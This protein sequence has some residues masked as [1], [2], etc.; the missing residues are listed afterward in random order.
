MKEEAKDLVNAIGALSEMTSIF[1]Q[2]LL[3]NGVEHADALWPT[4]QFL[5][6]SLI[7]PSNMEET[8]E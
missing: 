5:A 3:N 7:K 6:N 2:G 4:N 8:N 1:Y